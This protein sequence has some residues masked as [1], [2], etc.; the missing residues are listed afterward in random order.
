MICIDTRTTS[1]VEL[2]RRTSLVSEAKPK[3][4]CR[5]YPPG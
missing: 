4:I 3:D 1:C 5:V 2:A